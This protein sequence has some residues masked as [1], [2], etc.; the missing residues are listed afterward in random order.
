M[1]IDYEKLKNE[2]EK[3]DQIQWQKELDKEIENQ[4]D[5]AIAIVSASILDVQLRNILLEYMIKEKDINKDLFEGN[6]PL[7]TFSSKIKACYYLGLISE[8]EYKNIDTIRKIRNDFAHQ[9]IN[10][11]FDNNQS[12]KDRCRNLY[13]PKNMY[14]PK[15]F[16]IPKDGK[17]P[18]LNLNPFVA[19]NSPKNRFIQVFYFLSMNL[20]DRIVDLSL[21][22]TVEKYEVKISTAEGF[23]KKKEQFSKLK[24]D[25]IEVKEKEIK[26]RLEINEMEE[27]AGKEKTVFEPIKESEYLKALEQEVQMYDY[28]ATVLENSYED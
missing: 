20:L 16:P 21:D 11:S 18:K 8:D 24:K 13:I 5:R 4:S 2:L 14:I 19:D 17:L 15:S 25:L 26:L 3:M 23:R 12:I 6:S 9:L 28:I 1:K 22:S 7:S 10:I 27:K